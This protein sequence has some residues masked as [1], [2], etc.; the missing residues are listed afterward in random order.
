M[1]LGEG[2]LVLLNGGF[3][4]AQGLCGRS[5]AGAAVQQGEA[6][7]LALVDGGAE[8]A[9]ALGQRRVGALEGV[10]AGAVQGLEEIA[11]PAG[12]AGAQ[13]RGLVPRPRLAL[14]ERHQGVDPVLVIGL[15]G[16][17]KGGAQVLVDHP[18]AQRL[19]DRDAFFQ[20]REG[21]VE[22]AAAAVDTG[23]LQEHLRLAERV[24]PF[25]VQRQG[26]L[27]L[28]A[29]G[30]AVAHDPVRG[31]NG[32]AG[33]GLQ[34][35]DAAGE[36]QGLAAEVERQ[37]GLSQPD[38]EEGE[39]ADRGGLAL[40][41]LQLL[42]QLERILEERQRLLR[43]FHALE[44]EAPVVEERGRGFHL[45]AVGVVVLAHDLERLAVVG[46]RFLPVAEG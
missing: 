21:L 16:G 25:A 43:L 7:V 39:V 23:E 15:P 29:R 44:E 13:G 10:E 42:G 40:G 19:D 14:V 22:I 27:Q 1:Q 33:G 34:D 37:G 36:L 9:L 5:G 32:L 41:A 31:P 30:F 28:P 2:L 24:A 35:L 6:A 46:E 17:E 11:R 12:F 26:E 45:Q 20:V 4:L 18:A 3:D 38:V 8:T